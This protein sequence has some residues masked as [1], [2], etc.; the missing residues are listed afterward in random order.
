M[1]AIQARLGISDGELQDATQPKAGDE[2]IG[3]VGHLAL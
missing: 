2:G 1:G 3:N